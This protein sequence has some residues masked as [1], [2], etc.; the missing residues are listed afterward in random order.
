VDRRLVAG[1]VCLLCALLASSRLD[2]I[3]TQAPIGM[4][5]E[6]QAS[7]PRHYDAAVETLLQGYEQAVGRDLVPAERKQVGLKLNTRSGKGLSTPLALVRATILALERRGYSRDSILLVDYST[8]ALRQA[9]IY[10]FVNEGDPRFE[11]CPVLPLDTERYYDPD[12]FYD[13]PLPPSM[14]QEPQYL[15]SARRGTQELVAGARER[16]SFLA[17]PLLH[18][19]DFWINMPTMV[20]DPALGVDG[21]LANATLWNVSNSQRF[22]A[23]DATASAAVA[24]IAAIPELNERMVLHLISLERYQFIGGPNFNARY[25]VSEPRLWL[26]SDPVAL[27][28]LLYDRMN[29]QR[30]LHGFPLITPIPRQF[31]FAASLGLGTYDSAAI[32]VRQLKLGNEDDLEESAGGSQESP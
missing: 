14:Q 23:N 20:D 32:H 16:K 7:S 3:P 26:S 29:R 11:G 4:V 5:F 6:V 25:S 10:P 21:A 19:V 9:G 15:S 8:H 18:E 30:M 13:S 27:D 24:E 28:R 17:A 2:A 12:W 31:P 22:L 1:L